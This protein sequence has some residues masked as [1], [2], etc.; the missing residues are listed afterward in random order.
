MKI[1]KK[2]YK[3]WFV[4]GWSL[5]TIS[6]IIV[7]RPFLRIKH[8]ASQ[9]KIIIFY[10]HTLN[11]NLRSFFDYLK[12]EKGFKPYFLSIDSSYLKRLERAGEDSDDL[13]SL[14]KP[15]DL[16]SI[17]RSDAFVSSH[18]LHFLRVLK[19]TTDIKFFDVWH[20]IPYKGFAASD[21]NHLHDH[22]QS[23]VSSEKL[24]DIYVNKFGF[25]AERVKV[26]GYGRVDQLVDGSLRDRQ[27]LIDKYKLP[28][29]DK[30]V[31]IAPTWKQDDKGRNILPFNTEEKE[32]F[33]KVDEVARNHNAEI[34]FRTHLNSQE[35]I[36]TDG[37]SNT[38]F[39][40][41]SKY[42]LAEEF[43]ALSDVLVSDWSSISF[44]YLA[45]DRP[46]IFLDIKHPF[47]NGLSFGAE[48]R[49]G[50]IVGSFDELIEVLDKNLESPQAY[51]NRNQEKIE[52]TKKA[53]YDD[54]LDGKSCERYLKEL[55]EVL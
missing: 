24:K 44:D 2:N 40:P 48:Y 14:L 34:I 28:A 31:L 32:F 7:M 53:A 18:G 9:N 21:F 5:V 15:K 29:R 41:Y 33:S 8:K 43:L 36:S 46:T 13:L 19:K 51:M 55:N 49:F 1:D 54:T 10:G 38:K 47:K 16:P 11:G 6:L 12:R 23:W 22:D 35:E 25:D 30:Y 42:E 52:M 50:D 3:H 20:G 17:A 45:L 39:M 4:L 37:L 27:R 26:T